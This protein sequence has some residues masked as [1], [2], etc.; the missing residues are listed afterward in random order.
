MMVRI[1]GQLFL[2]A[3]PILTKSGSVN[4]YDWAARKVCFKINP[5]CLDQFLIWADK[6]IYYEESKNGKTLFLGI[7]CSV[8]EVIAHQMAISYGEEHLKFLLTPAEIAGLT[9]LLTKAKER[10]YGW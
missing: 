8:D 10:I 2:E 7:D 9:I 4:I 5:Q 1:C 3:A 6:S